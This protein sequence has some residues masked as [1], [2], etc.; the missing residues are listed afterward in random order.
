LAKIGKIGLFFGM[1]YISVFYILN[2]YFLFLLLLFV[3]FNRNLKEKG[4]FEAQTPGLKGRKEI[5]LLSCPIDS[6]DYWNLL[7]TI[8][9]TLNYVIVCLGND[10]ITLETVANLCNYAV[11][12]RSVESTLNIY[13]RSY[14]EEKNSQLKAMCSDIS[15]KYKKHGVNVET[16]GAKAELF[17]YEL[18]V[19]DKLLEEAKEYNYAYAGKKEKSIL[20]EKAEAKGFYY[21]E[22]DFPVNICWNNEL[23]IRRNCQYSIVD[24][25][26]IERRCASNFSNSLH[27][28]TKIE[29]LGKCGDI[30]NPTDAVR[31]S[32]AMTEHERWN[33]TMRLSGWQ[34]FVPTSENH[35]NDPKLKL[36]P[37]I[38]KFDDI[39]SWSPEMQA[40]YQGY[41]YEVVNTTIDLYKQEN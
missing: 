12:C 1:C 34:S 8:L 28:K 3:S 41:D 29:I 30:I 23:K 35:D 18:V 25:E 4:L 37:L 16:F 15:E 10:D 5:E 33:A 32:L 11:R 38:C 21:K 27:A 17:T 31:T 36:A 22:D 2:I 20:I 19:R 24:L 6:E 26:E 40:E 7:K 9:P 39:H 14:G 13:V